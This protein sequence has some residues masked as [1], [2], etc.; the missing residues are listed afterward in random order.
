MEF[1]IKYDPWNVTETRIADLDW[2]PSDMNYS[3]EGQER[4]HVQVEQKNPKYG[5]NTHCG[6]FI[7]YT[8][9]PLSRL[10]EDTARDWRRLSLSG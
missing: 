3:W 8:R 5:I 1:L 10:S 9:V 6:G 4:C 2:I 7:L